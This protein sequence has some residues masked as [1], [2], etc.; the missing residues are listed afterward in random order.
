MRVDGSGLVGTY[1][2]YFS[3]NGIFYFVDKE[4]NTLG[5]ETDTPDWGAAIQGDC[6]LTNEGYY[7]ERTGKV[8]L[9]I[10]ASTASDPVLYKIRNVRSGK[11]LKNEGDQLYQTEDEGDNFY[12]RK[13]TRC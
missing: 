10:V 4:G 1:A 7:W 8:D 3:S 2:N 5:G 9:P 6:G 12:F 13:K 11:F